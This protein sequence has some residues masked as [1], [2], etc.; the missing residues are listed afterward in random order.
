MALRDIFNDLFIK[1]PPARHSPLD[2]G[3]SLFVNAQKAGKALFPSAPLLYQG[4]KTGDMQPYLNSFPNIRENPQV[5]VDKALGFAAPMEKRIFSK[6]SQKTMDAFN[7]SKNQEAVGKFM[8]GTFGKNSGVNKAGQSD[9]FPFN[10][11]Q[12]TQK[13]IKEAFRASDDKSNYR[14]DNI[15]WIAYMPNGEKRVIYTRLN[16]QGH[17]E[18]LN[19]HAVS[20]PDFIK[21]LSHFGVPAETRTRIF[22]LERSTP[23][24]LADKDKT[25]IPQVKYTTRPNKGQ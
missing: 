22:S 15:A 17:E 1:P 2:L 11:L 18:I 21:D 14:S 12:E 16:P 24:Q 10:E 5:A 9:R 13:H 19:W 8:L 4:V 20:N 23:I 25:T 3:Q 6:G 7:A